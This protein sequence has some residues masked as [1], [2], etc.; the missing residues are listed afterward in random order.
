MFCERCKNIEATI[1]L[2]EIIKDVKSELHLCENCAR[3]IGLNSKLS[4]FSLSIPEMLSFL[5]IDEVDEYAGGSACKS[6]GLTFADYSRE[7]KLGC[8]DCYRYLGESLKSV[9]AGY[10][11]AS[12]HAGKHPNNHSGINSITYEKPAVQVSPK[13]SMEEL[14]TMLNRAVNDERYEEAALLRD[15]IRELESL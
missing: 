5:D 1:H 12:R 13:K 7:S 2:T 3:E 11:G 14:K 15:K 4:N 8:P 10:H 6:C 9:I